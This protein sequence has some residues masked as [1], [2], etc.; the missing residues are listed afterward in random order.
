MGGFHLRTAQ[1]FEHRVYSFRRRIA[2]ELAGAAPQ[3]AQHQVGID[4]RM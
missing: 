3:A 2:D 4:A 1:P